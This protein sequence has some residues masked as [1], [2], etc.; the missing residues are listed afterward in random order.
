MTYNATSA[1]AQTLLS[2]IAKLTKATGHVCDGRQGIYT[3]A[4]PWSAEVILHCITA[5]SL[6]ATQSNTLVSAHQR[7]V[8][9]SMPSKF[10]P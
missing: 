5:A 8:Y 2:P 1:P 10:V 4:S 6:R 7:I 9:N 3:A